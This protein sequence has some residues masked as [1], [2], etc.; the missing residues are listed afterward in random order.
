[1]EKLAIVFPGMGYHADKPLLYYSK[2]MARS[3]GYKIIDLSYQGFPKP[4]KE[5]EESMMQIFEIAK[6]QTEEQLKEIDGSKA[7][8]LLFLSKSVGTIVAVD[9]A[10]RHQLSPKFVLYTPLRET[11][12][13]M[14]QEKINAIAFHGTKDGWADT[15]ILQQGCKEHDIPLH[16][17]EQGNHSLESQDILYDIRKLQSVM[18]ITHEFLLDN[19]NH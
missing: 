18:Q 17:I 6:Q 8:D 12:R 9:Y 3:M 11:F 7:L 14:K 1:M 19:E 2:K 5:S 4:E 10:Y 15:K 16:L 13:V